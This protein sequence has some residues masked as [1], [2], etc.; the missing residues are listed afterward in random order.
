MT[1]AST[2]RAGV[3]DPLHMIHLDGRYRF[4]APPDEVWHH[5]NRVD[6]FPTWWRWL[7][8]FQVEGGGLTSGGV[9]RGLVVP[10]IPYR[11]RVGIALDE[12][13]PAERIV[14][15]LTGDLE[16]PAELGLTEVAGGA[17]LTIRW[18]VEMR[19]PA[20]RRAASVAK[21]LLVWGHDQVIEIT[22]RRFQAVVD[23]RL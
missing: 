7:R 18:D 9:L 1:K 20:M 3:P 17:E 14:A 15:T 6:E 12:V 5:M 22:V 13:A 11:F 8:E 16:G 10:P 23:G 4:P 19:K 21:P 2:R